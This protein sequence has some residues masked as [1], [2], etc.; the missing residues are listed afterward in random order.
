MASWRQ[1]AMVGYQEMAR[2]RWLLEIAIDC[3][4]QKA[5]RDNKLDI[6][7]STDSKQITIND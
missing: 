1:L 7:K 4:L 2:W 5:S 6:A 3:K